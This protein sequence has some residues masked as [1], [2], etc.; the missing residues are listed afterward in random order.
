MTDSSQKQHVPADLEKR[1][2]RHH[3]VRRLAIEKRRAGYITS[4]IQRVS[5]ENWHSVYSLIGIALKITGLYARG[6]K[7]TAQIQ[8]RHNRIRHAS[9]PE[10]FRGFRILQISDLH[11][12]MSGLAVQ[13]LVEILPEL[14]YDVCVLTG[15]YRGQTYAPCEPALAGLA[16]VRPVLREPIYG[17]LGNHDTTDMLLALEE[18]GARM[19]LNESVAIERAGAR[20]HFAGVDDAHYYRAHNIEKAL[21]AIP[22]DEFCVLLSH[23]PEIYRQAAHGGCS[24]MLS[25]HTHGGQICLPGGIPIR[26]NAALPRR[27]GSGPWHFQAMIGYTSTGVGVSGV[28]VRFNC[29]P[30]ITLHHLEPA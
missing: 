26:L 13:R 28:P 8:I 3:A 27:M 6:V 18:M 9:V 15:D 16:R 11:A 17:V 20:I 4:G 22:P 10:A 24:L 7:N 12:D 23:T 2:G 30:E 21:A 1:L 25:G 14:S 29:P 5:S 19:L